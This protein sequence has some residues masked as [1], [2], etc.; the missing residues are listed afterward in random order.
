MEQKT[1]APTGPG[2]K[3][4]RVGAPM[5]CD[6]CGFELERNLVACSGC[7][8]LYHRDCWD[9][10]D[11]CAWYACRLADP[12]PQPV[13]A[14]VELIRIPR[15]RSAGWWALAAAAV[16]ALLVATGQPPARRALPALKP[17]SATP[18]V[19]VS[20]AATDLRSTV[21]TIPVFRISTG[22]VSLAPATVAT[23]TGQPEPG[24]LERRRQVE[25]STV[26]LRLVPDGRGGFRFEMRQ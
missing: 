21:A 25:R 15:P 7:D 14:R 16:G 20:R 10:N 13:P 11:G 19:M 9:R 2:R 24:I 17:A 8:S 12:L 5:A 3:V 1:E 4:V 23:A 26:G 22:T 18:S 6:V